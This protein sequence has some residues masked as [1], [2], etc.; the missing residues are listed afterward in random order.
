[1]KNWIS[2]NLVAASAALLI[3]L[4][5]TGAA[6]LLRYYGLHVSSIHRHL[7]QAMLLVAPA[8]AWRLRGALRAEASRIVV[9]L[10]L[11]AMLGAGAQWLLGRRP[12]LAPT[13]STTRLIQA[14]LA[15]PL[16]DLA[17]IYHTEP[18][19]LAAR[20]REVGFV[21]AGPGQSPGEVAEASNRS[22]REALGALT[23]FLRAPR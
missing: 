18:E 21:V 12:R 23:E 7:G 10:L 15:T 20:L 16:V 13:D 6:I 3:G 5:L 14:L 19:R 11:L 1:M 4:A 9:L 8:L 22:G 17:P 2:R